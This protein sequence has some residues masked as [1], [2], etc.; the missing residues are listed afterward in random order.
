MKNH[1]GDL[2]VPLLVRILF[3]VITRN[4]YKEF[5][6]NLSTKWDRN[7]RILTIAQYSSTKDLKV[8]DG[9]RNAPNICC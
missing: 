4:V 6:E 2:S 1:H 3:K 8:A 9:P 7:R 5:V